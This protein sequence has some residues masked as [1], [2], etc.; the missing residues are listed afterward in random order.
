M[1]TNQLDDQLV[2]WFGTSTHSSILGQLVMNVGLT[3]E[4]GTRYEYWCINYLVLVVL[5]IG[6]CTS[7]CIESGK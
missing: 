7:T 6:I 1:T 4:F 2:S 3:A 5:V